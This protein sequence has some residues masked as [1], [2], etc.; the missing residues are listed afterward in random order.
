[1]R[2]R[3]RLKNAAFV[4]VYMRFFHHLRMRLKRCGFKRKC[5]TSLTQIADL[6]VLC[7]L[8]DQRSVMSPPPPPPPRDKGGVN[9]LFHGI[10]DFDPNS[11]RVHLTMEKGDTVFFH[12][13]LIHGS[14]TNKTAGF[15][16]GLLWDIPCFPVS[17]NEAIEK[18]DFTS[19][20]CHYASSDCYYIDVKGTIQE[21]IEKEVVEMSKKRNGIDAHT[22]LKQTLLQGRYEW[23]FSTMPGT[24][25]NFSAVSGTVRVVP[26]GH[27]GG[28]RVPRV[29][30]DTDD[31]STVFVRM[32]GR[33][34]RVL[35]R[36][37]ESTCNRCS[38]FLVPLRRVQVLNVPPILE[39]CDF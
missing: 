36:E 14:G 12:P 39:L 24:A 25:L 6:T 22:S 23:G 18:T 30:M 1:M 20:S 29:H 11:P 9:K 2:Q 34:K 7:N 35:C 19:I 8:L 21:N 27:T 17:P 31:S 26:S 16:K 37:R 28:T 38:D 4:R 5:E 10:R 13:S 15:R 3:M 32:H 33:Q